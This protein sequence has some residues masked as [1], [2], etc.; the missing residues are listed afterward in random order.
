M[1]RPN[2]AAKGAGKPNLSFQPGHETCLCLYDRDAGTPVSTIPLSDQQFQTVL[3]YCIKNRIEI[4]EFIEE[5]VLEKLGKTES[6]VQGFFSKATKGLPPY[7]RKVIEGMRSKTERREAAD[8]MSK[9][10]VIV[11]SSAA[12]LCH[13]R[14]PRFSRPKGI[15]LN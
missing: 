1:K 14:Q 5:A 13:G 15:Q 2:R 6:P 4:E 11:A 3:L 12:E 10:A 8:L 9:W 7:L